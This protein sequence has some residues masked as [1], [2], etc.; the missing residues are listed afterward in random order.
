[1]YTTVSCTVADGNL[2]GTQTTLVSKRG[3]SDT[4]KRPV[5]ARS[6]ASVAQDTYLSMA[7]R[8]DQAR[9]KEK[10]M[11]LRRSPLA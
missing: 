4:R 2:V 7:A 11:L 8:F 3:V 1:M 9:E 5:S 10:P 6:G